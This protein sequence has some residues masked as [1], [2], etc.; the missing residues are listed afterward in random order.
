M[1]SSLACSEG[2]ALIGNG[3]H[4]SCADKE[5]HLPEITSFLTR[6]SDRFLVDLNEITGGHPF[7]GAASPSPHA[8]AHVHFDNTG[9]RYPYGND[10]PRNYPAI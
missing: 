7:K 8:G 1:V 2:G 3:M 4:G 9:S 5:A 6:P 10:K